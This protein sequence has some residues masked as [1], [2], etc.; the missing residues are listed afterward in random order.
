MEYGPLIKF[1]RTQKGITQKELAKGICSI[2]HLCKIENNSKDANKQTLSLLMKRL[3]VQLESIV[4]KDEQIKQLIFEVNESID[5]YLNDLADFKMRK[6][7]E[8][9]HVVPFTDFLHT[10]ELTKYRY[11]IFKEDL[12][13]AKNQY[14]LLFKQ[15]NIFSE[16]QLT[17]YHYLY[18]VWMLKKGF[19]KRADELLSSISRESEIGISPGELL[20]H[21]AIV[22]TTL[23]ETGYAIYFGKL[24]LEEFMAD[25]NLKRSL[26]MLMLLGITYTNSKIYEE[27]EKCYKHLIR[28]AEILGEN[29][30]LPE[31][32]HNV[33]Y[34]KKKLGYFVEA[35]Q[36]FE[37]S[38]SLQSE[39]SK[40]F[41]VTLY[42]LGEVYFLLSHKDEAKGVFQKVLEI[43]SE[44]EDKKLALLANYY[45]LA[46]EC[47]VKALTFSEAKVIPFLEEK[48]DKSEELIG[49]YEK[50]SNH[51]Q[52]IGRFEEAVKYIKKIN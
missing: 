17:L 40:H 8:F 29:K 43:G 44:R 39:R 4:D 51:Y 46:M 37:R 35:K 27:A 7:K 11:Y 18:A 49:F 45:L 28:N 3:G 9:E 16:S 38:L 15:K 30:L 21:R 48:E 42:S 2:S 19:Y 24:A 32:Y 10:Y 22:K 6:L 36:F 33:G 14:E 34:L 25:H 13:Q 1:Y 12:I 31:I 23:E 52:K 20:Y 41:L 50:L 26:H 47:P 5:Y